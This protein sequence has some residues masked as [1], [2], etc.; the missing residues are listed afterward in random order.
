M[1]NS[2]LDFWQSD[3]GRAYMQRNAVSA[4]D[5]E[6]RARAL[7]RILANIPTP[8][9]TVLEVGSGPG[10]NLLALRRLLP[11]ARLFAVE[12]NEH[13]R[14]LSALSGAEVYDGHAGAIPAADATFDLVLTAGVLI[15]VHPDRLRSCMVE[16][17]RVSR[18]HVVA[19]EYFAPSCE[20][21][22]YYGADR[23]WRNDFGSIYMSI[24]LRPV[25]SGFFWKP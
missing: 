1:T 8:P 19:I 23:I 14:E 10:G 22:T 25:A 24:G 7:A 18:Q 3:H 12:P 11:D 16:I 13:A 4:V 6:N 21:V 2:E 5:V 17:A 15:H 20:P 9:R